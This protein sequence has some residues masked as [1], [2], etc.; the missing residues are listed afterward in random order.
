MK[1]YIIMSGCITDVWPYSV[2]SSRELAEEEI[3]AHQKEYY[4]PYIEERE[5][6]NRLD[7]G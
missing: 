6:D 3:R 2:W 5:V 4:E 7:V 1:V